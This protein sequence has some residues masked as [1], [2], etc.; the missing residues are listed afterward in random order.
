MKF[1]RIYI[2][3][4]NSCNL[5]CSFC[6]GTKR[7]TAF[8]SPAAFSHILKQIRPFSDT[9]YLHV[10]GEPLLHPEFRELLEMAQGANFFIHITTNGT[11]LAKRMDDLRGR[12]RQCNI[13]LHSFHANPTQADEDYVQ[14]CLACGDDLAQHQTYVSYR[15]WNAH[16][17]SL[18]PEDQQIAQILADHYHVS[19]SDESHQRLAPRRFLHRENTFVWPTL[20]LPVL[21][22]T[23]TC[24]GMRSH[25]AILVDG[26]VVP[27]CLD[28]EGTMT[29][30]NVFQTAFAQIITQPRVESMRV[31]FQNGRMSESLCMHCSYRLR[32]TRKERI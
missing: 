10:L 1:K 20:E 27:C 28:S 7:R 19:L 23:G 3:I 12:I 26:S 5:N 21:K 14:N 17:G 4:T 25:C 8:M 2:E 18:K 6:A 16:N 31:N 13:S 11:L 32:F 29:L 22:Q 15:L 24:Y 9:I 30:G